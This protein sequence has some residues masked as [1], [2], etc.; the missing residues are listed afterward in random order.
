MELPVSSQAL[1]FAQ[2]ALLSVGLCLFYDLLR[3]LRRLC[4]RVTGAADVLFA[5]TLG[6]SLLL[7]ALLAGGGQFRL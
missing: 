5:L 1:Q 6:V 2:A 4:P 7:F 3:A